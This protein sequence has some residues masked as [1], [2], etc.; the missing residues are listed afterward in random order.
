MKYTLYVDESGDSG[1]ERVQTINTGGATPFMTLGAVLIPES[2]KGEVIKA[3]KSITKKL[4]K[5]FL[6]CKNLKHAQ[7]V[8]YARTLSQQKILCFGVI[9]K[10]ETLGSYKT[11]ING[12]STQYY[13][14]CAQYLLEKVGKFMAIHE[15]SEGDV[16]I[17]FEEGNFNYSSLRGL[18]GKCRQN[19]INAETKYL[20]RINPSS[21]STQ[22][23]DEE[24]LLQPADLTAHALFCSVSKT[25]TN[26]LI[27]EPRYLTELKSKFFHDDKTG[28]I[29]SYGIKAVHKLSEL[30]LDSDIHSL[31]K[32]LKA[33]DITFSS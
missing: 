17:V 33:K 4:G 14:K 23:K 29:D 22:N 32:T 30:S 7:K 18:I 25:K 5:D 26:F 6:H 3:V 16:N 19:P 10:K 28:L 1:I 2:E 21:I 12:N 11:A 15:I 27:P 9:S 24:P 8:F 31:L 13:N 20:L